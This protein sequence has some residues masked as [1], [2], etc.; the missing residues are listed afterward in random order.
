MNINT[1]KSKPKTQTSS[2]GRNGRSPNSGCSA[3]FATSTFC[4]CTAISAPTNC[5]TGVTSLSASA[6]AA[7]AA[8]AARSVSSCTSACRLFTPTIDPTP[9]I[10][11]T[12]IKFILASADISADTF[13]N[14]D[15]LTS[16]GPAT[17]R[18]RCCCRC[19]LQYMLCVKS[20]RAAVYRTL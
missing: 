15:C 5:E 1:K 11:F 2:R 9:C 8:A 4:T 6:A 10:S 7:A 13:L 20:S 19:G 3:G 16:S 14:E 17:G 12:L 18:R